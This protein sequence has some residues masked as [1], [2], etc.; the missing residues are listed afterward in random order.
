MRPIAETDQRRFWSKVNLPNQAGCMLWKDSPS[1]YGYGRL[2]LEGKQVGAHRVSLLL[3][4][5]PPPVGKNL[6]THTC[7]NRT[8]VA[9]AH[10]RWADPQENADDRERDGT[11]LRGERHGQAKLTAEQVQEIRIRYASGGALQQTLADE[12]GVQ[13]A[14]I[15]K[16]VLGH[17]WQEGGNS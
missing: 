10:L 12:Y 6:A 1:F 17:K 13:Q 15:S 16:I 7:R 14:A 2:R 9:P 4:E 3:S 11:A 8:C 5:G